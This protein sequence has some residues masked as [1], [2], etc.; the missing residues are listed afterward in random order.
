MAYLASQ[1]AEKIEE[2]QV[3]S[4]VQQFVDFCEAHLLE[5][6]PSTVDHTVPG[7]GLRLQQGQVVSL[8][9]RL[10]EYKPP[11]SNNIFG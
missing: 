7:F 11:T 1:Y 8:A 9:P 2:Q 10:A 5:N 6:E 4:E 3:P